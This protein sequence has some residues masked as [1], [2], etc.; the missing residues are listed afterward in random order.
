MLYALSA[1]LRDRG[2]HPVV[3]LREGSVPV[4]HFVAGG[5]DT[6]PVPRG[7]LSTLTGLMQMGKQFRKERFD[8]IHVHRNHDLPTGKLLSL[9]SGKLPVLLTQHCRLGKSLPLVM[10][11]PDRIVTVSRFICDG[12]RERF[13]RA[14]AK[15]QVVPNGIDLVE[16]AQ[17]RNDYW[18]ARPELAGKWPLL[19]VVGLF[20]KNQEGVIELLPRLREAFPELMLVIIGRD[21]A[22]RG[23]LELQA[24][25]LG[26]SDL[27]FFAGDLPFADM[28]HALAG[29]DLN[30]SAYRCEGFGLSVI[31]GMAVGTPFAGYRSGGYT[32]TVEDGVNGVLADTKDQ[33]LARIIEVLGDGT[34]LARLAEAARASVQDRYSLDRMLDLYLA[35]Y[36]ELL[37][38]SQPK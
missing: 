7:G 17:A 33:L 28:K 10:D 16:F 9:W 13:P 32:D 36:A 22:K 12:I 15:L 34:T 25:S 21:D 29:L 20:Y 18:S 38:G 37:A 1:G 4:Q 35:T 14:A 2:H 31:E 24:R 5:F 11:M 30:V 26:V 3:F 27:L 23:G 8:L 6:R 19:G